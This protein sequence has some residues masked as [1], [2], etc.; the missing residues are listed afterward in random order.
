MFKGCPGCLFIVRNC[1]NRIDTA[2]GRNLAQFGAVHILYDRYSNVQP[3][4]G[5]ELMDTKLVV[6][7]FAATPKRL[8]RLITLI[9]LFQ[10]MIEYDWLLCYRETLDLPYPALSLTG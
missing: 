5:S 9:S 6:S 4:G 7:A 2:A 8:G 1:L 10:T 3:S